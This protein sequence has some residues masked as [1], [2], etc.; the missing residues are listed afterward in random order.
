MYSM[1][2]PHSTKI[3][4][5]V[6]ILYNNILITMITDS[7]NDNSVIHTELV[8]LHNLLDKYQ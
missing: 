4:F 1:F 6:R 7:H 2:I 8:T 5:I 3:Q